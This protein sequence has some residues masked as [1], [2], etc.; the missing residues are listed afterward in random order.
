MLYMIVLPTS[1]HTKFVAFGMICDFLFFLV[2]LI[3]MRLD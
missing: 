3:A 1:L 2:N